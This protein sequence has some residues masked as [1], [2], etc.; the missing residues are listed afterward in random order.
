MDKITIKEIIEDKELLKLV[1]AIKGV[2]K[3]KG[4]PVK[5]MV[6]SGRKVLRDAPYRQKDDARTALLISLDFASIGKLNERTVKMEE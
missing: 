1:V 2:S 4:I 6:E 5:E 3:E